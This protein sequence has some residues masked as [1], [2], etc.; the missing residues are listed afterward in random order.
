MRWQQKWKQ[1]RVV[2][3]SVTVGMV[4]LL[5]LYLFGYG[6]GSQ[7][8]SSQSPTPQAVAV[9]SDTLA[10][11]SN[12]VTKGINRFQ[13]MIDFD[14]YEGATVT[15]SEQDSDNDGFPDWCIFDFGTN[16]DGFAGKV[17]L[18]DE[19][20]AHKYTYENFQMSGETW[21]GWFRMPDTENF[22]AGE[23][24]ADLSITTPEGVEQMQA[25][26]QANVTWQG[27][28]SLIGTI[29]A[30]GSGDTCLLTILQTDPLIVDESHPALFVDGKGI[31]TFTV[32]GEAGGAVWEFTGA[33]N[34]RLWLD[35][36]GN[37]I[38]DAGEEMGIIS[39]SQTGQWQA[40]TAQTEL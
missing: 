14:L 12:E 3:F 40:S 6:G 16:G 24:Q 20:N 34:S 5:N 33:G 25:N 10:A 2:F 38:V 37:G 19:G 29:S 9:V 11:L 8:S 26:L 35:E 27:K 39:D 15:K 31:I 23:Y 28:L 21:S 32:N 36:N 30:T 18:D 1:I 22:P 17:R 13:R 4:V 7:S